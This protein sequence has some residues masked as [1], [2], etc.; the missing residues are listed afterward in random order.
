MA[1]ATEKAQRSL[2]IIEVTEIRGNQ[3]GTKM[4][5]EVKR[6]GQEAKS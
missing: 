5:Y 6:I 2:R 4:V 3:I 1:W